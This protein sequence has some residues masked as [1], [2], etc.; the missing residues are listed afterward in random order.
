MDQEYYVLIKIPEDFSNNATTLL[1]DEP[2]K[3]DLIYAPNE[4]FNFLAGQLGETAMLLI[5]STLEKNI[6]EK[7]AS[8]FFNNVDKIGEGLREASDGQENLNDGGDDLLD[9]SSKLK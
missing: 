4:G 3:L 8:M 9:G 2:E 1:D 7:Y 5:E 6:I